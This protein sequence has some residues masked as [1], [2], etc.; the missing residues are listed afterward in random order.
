MTADAK[1]L[2]GVIGAAH[3]IRGEVRVKSYTDEPMALAGYGPL[4]DEAGRTVE[5]VN[6]RPAKADMLVV[7]IKG[8]GDRNG[9]EALNGVKLY[10][11]RDCL[12][13]P[14]EDE[15]YHA[16]LIGL[17]AETPDG[18]PLGTVRTVEDH[19]AGDILDIASA[20]GGPALM[21]PFTRAVVPRI[22]IAGGRIVVDPPHEIIVNGTAEDEA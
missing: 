9:A 20:G 18:T 21:V 4:T 15:F 5:I 6:A 1:I 13:E 16:D 7:R 12:P 22:D 10:V 2:L 17:A 8:V 14:D 3:G 19:G 11:G